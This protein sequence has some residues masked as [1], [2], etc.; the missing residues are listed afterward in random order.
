MKKKTKC[1][2][3]AHERAAKGSGLLYENLGR[4]LIRGLLIFGLI[5]GMI[6]SVSANVCML[7]D[8]RVTNDVNTSVYP[9]LAVDSNNNVHISWYDD[10]DGN[11]EIYYKKCDN[12]GNNLTGDVRV[13]ND[14]SNSENPSIAV[15]SDNNVHIS[16]VDGRDGNSEIYYK[17]YDNDGNILTGDVRVTNDASNSEDP[18]I[19]VDSDNN[20]HISWEDNRD[21]NPE[22]YYKK[23]DNN[24]DNLTG[25]VRVTNDTSDSGLPSIAV[26]SDNNVHISWVDG[27][28]GNSEIYYKKLDNN[29]NTLTGDV[30]V[31]NDANNSMYPSI[32][33]DSDNNVHISWFDDRD[34]NWEIYYKKLDITGML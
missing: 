4:N 14:A 24:G 19:A 18:S 15:D 25:D 21:G 28:D 3:S 7:S 5:F 30:R 31:T 26:D 23:Y 12:N 27:R 20:V 2:A 1:A 10:R 34:G 9:S 16:W 32:A 6:A 22:I 33:V 13:T 11:S 29:G 8:V 17:K